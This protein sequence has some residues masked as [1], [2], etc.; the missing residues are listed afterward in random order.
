MNMNRL[1]LSWSV[2]RGQETYGYSMCRLDSDDS[3][4]RYR[5]IGG[6][7]DMVGTV[8]GDW[9]TAEHQDKLQALW[10]ANIQNV[11]QYGSHEQIG[12]IYGLFRNPKNGRVYVD[13]A[14]GRSSVERIAQGCGIDLEVVISKRGNLEGWVASWE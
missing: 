7:Y 1:S 13:G 12:G 3:G 9:L 8:L 11:Q 6:G 2:S 4:K 14:C 5:T 10:Q